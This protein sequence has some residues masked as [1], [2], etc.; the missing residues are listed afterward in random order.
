LWRR[1]ATTGQFANN[2]FELY[3]ATKA[4]RDLARSAAQ[5]DYEG[6]ESNT[7][8]LTIPS[9]VSLI[10][11]IISDLALSAM[12]DTECTSKY[13]PDATSATD[14]A[15][16]CSKYV[17]DALLSAEYAVGAIEAMLPAL[18]HPGEPPHK[19][20]KSER[21]VTKFLKFF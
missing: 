7:K 12:D 19:S 16:S 21:L 1:R 6:T 4:Y 17:P 14:D 10:F 8:V 2:I 13:V 18:L 15:E 9:T 20:D 3:T 11:Q 5:A